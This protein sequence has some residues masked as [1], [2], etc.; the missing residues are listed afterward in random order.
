MRPSDPVDLTNCD[1]E[2]IHI[3]GSIQ[4]HGCV[5]VCD[6]EGDRVV[7][8][9]ANA[10]E[11]L[12]LDPA[13]EGAMLVALVGDQIVHRIRNALASAK[14]L[15]RQALLFGQEIGGALFDIAVHRYAGAV[16]VELE[17]AGAASMQPLDT[18]RQ[19]VRRLAEIDDGDRMIEEATRL[20]RAFLG[21]DR[22]M[23]Y[24]FEDDGSGKVV[25]EAR[26]AGLERFLGQ[27]F[28]ASDIPQ[29]ARILYRRNPIRVIPD[30]GAAPVPLLPAAAEAGAPVDL[31][32]AH[33]RSVSPIH[34]EYLGNMG[35]SA[36]MSIS[37][38]P[39]DAL[40]GLVA[41]H[42]YA[43]KVLSMGERVAAE[44]FGA[45]FSLHLHALAQQRRLDTA[46]RARAALERLLRLATQRP[47]V[48]AL[49]AEHLEDLSRLVPCDGIGLWLG[50]GW[51]A[52]GSTPPDAA[53]PPLARHIGRVSEGRVHAIHDLAG[54]LPEA[55][56]YAARAA[57]VLAVP[58]S[59]TPRDYLFFFRKELVHTLAWAGNPEKSYETGPLGD[60][61]TP[62]K[63]FAI[64]KET[65]RMQ[66]QRWSELD[67]ETGE[68]ARSMLAEV[69]LRHNELMAEERQKADV[70][71]RM[72]NE[73]LNHRVKN[74]LSIIKS[75]VSRPVDD[76]RS[77]AE[78][79]GALEGRIGALAVAHDQVVRGDG[80]GLISTL[81]EAELLPYGGGTDRV[82]LSGPPVWVD[83]RAFS[84]LALVLHELATN[85]A[86]YGA[87]SVTPGRLAVEWRLDERGDC[88]LL[89]RE[90]GGPPVTPPKRSGFGSALIERSVPYDLGGT[91]NIAFPPEGVEAR[92]VL[93][94][95]HLTQPLTEPPAQRPRRSRGVGQGEADL[96]ADTRV[97]LV[98]DQLLIAM[99]AEGLLASAGVTA[100]VIAGSAAEAMQRL[101]EATP[102]VAVLDVN[103]GDGTSIPVAE[104]LRRRGVPFIFAT[105]YGDTMMIPPEFA[106]VPV[107]RKPYAADTLVRAIA[108]AL[109]AA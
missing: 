108:E 58:L 19:L 9:S 83:A 29:Q 91:S 66:S 14:G 20:L 61:L 78:Y 89:W 94:A 93:P 8:H 47:D 99:D 60:R 51:T 46:M 25:A 43:P 62:R 33:L 26:R 16:I 34:L 64:W 84:V 54:A 107:V 40:W 70:R 41:C 18:A 79:A 56:D 36:S 92:L 53:I 67:R 90:R 65:V 86:K 37:I 27:Y 80:G 48:G 3:P 35:V 69:V 31:S 102:D 87:L 7:L 11:M 73:E 5:L 106:G 15:G 75:V 49:M 39:I 59:V 21:Y 38:I 57:G 97:L 74:I 10:A 76:G 28:P 13:L 45:F 103:L 85:A 88:H 77:L 12:G 95:R 98:E 101:A 81:L 30:V 6:G 104:E 2:P 42:H 44:V 50:G 1:R 109:A 72:L 100:V 52:T 17:P 71:Q 63:S 55:E 105:G 82:T 4:S 24:R 68:A 22:V 96:D 23:I 32:F